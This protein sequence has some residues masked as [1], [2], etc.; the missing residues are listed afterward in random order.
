MATGRFWRCNPSGEILNDAAGELIRREY[1]S[2]LK[3]VV[4]TYSAIFNRS[5]ASIYLTGSVSRGLAHA[6]SDIDF[7]SVLKPN[8]KI[9]AESEA[10]LRARKDVLEE[11]YPWIEKFDLE[12]WES[13]QLALGDNEF[14]IS[15]FIVKVHSVL[16]FGED[17]SKH[18]P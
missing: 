13:D 10:K 3:D 2:V 8:E 15:A 7:F 18:L 11:K 17:L 1:L 4:D 16:L 12:T 5:V 14:A 9:S 6:R